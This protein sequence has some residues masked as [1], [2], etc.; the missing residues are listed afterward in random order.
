MPTIARICYP[1]HSDLKNVARQN[2]GTITGDRAEQVRHAY[3]VDDDDGFRRSLAL[4]LESEGWL[5][6]SFA[7]ARDF[8]DSCP[9]LDP[10]LVLLDLHLPEVG[11]LDLLEAEHP[12]LRRFAVVVVTG[13]G[14]IRTAV[15]SMKAGALDFLEK[16]FTGSEVLARLDSLYAQF[17]SRQRENDRRLDAEQRIAALSTRERQ[18]LASLLAGL[19]NKLI[20]RDLELSPRTVEMHRARMLQK[21]GVAS[22]AEAISVGR[23]AGLEPASGNPDD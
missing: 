7:S 13:A 18:V 3:V 10:G 5:T 17:Q 16:P 2:G 21:L 23:F 6:R 11:G 1:G 9:E 8:L 4:L 19:S 14:E 22:T 20:A 12:E 15:R